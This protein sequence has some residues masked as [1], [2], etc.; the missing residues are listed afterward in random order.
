ME[1]ETG[2]EIRRF[3]YN[4]YEGTVKMEMKNNEAR[5]GWR[6]GWRPKA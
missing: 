4:E 3:R 1:G 2:F 5:E 6:E